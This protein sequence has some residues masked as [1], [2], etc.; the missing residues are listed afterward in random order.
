MLL[1]GLCDFNYT[2]QLMSFS[3][4]KPICLPFPAIDLLVC[5]AL[6]LNISFFSIFYW[7]SND[8][9]VPLPIHVLITSISP[10][11]RLASS[12][13]IIQTSLY[14]QLYH[15]LNNLHLDSFVFN[16][17]F[18]NLLTF[19]R[20]VMVLYCFL[21]VWIFPIQIVSFQ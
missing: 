15:C 10:N 5:I 17:D 9:P 13:Q 14:S 12:G 3:R 1:A 20:I 7:P 8:H 2:S 6:S 21:Y 16:S 11:S 19:L 4:G 18:I